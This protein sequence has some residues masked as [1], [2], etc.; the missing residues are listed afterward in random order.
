MALGAPDASRVSAEP[1]LEGGSPAD[2]A[3][4]RDA[5]PTS[6]GPLSPKF[7]AHEGSLRRSG[8]DE[9]VEAA[10]QLVVPEPPARDPVGDEDGVEHHV[11]RDKGEHHEPHRASEDRLERRSRPTMPCSRRRGG[12]GPRT[13]RRRGW[14]NAC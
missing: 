9:L 10:L 14:R 6:S 2:A 1:F 7:G 3:G 5:A 13:R 12:T 11:E 4:A 8:L